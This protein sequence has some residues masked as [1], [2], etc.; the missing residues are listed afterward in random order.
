MPPGY[1]ASMTLSSSTGQKA[2]GS[3]PVPDVHLERESRLA[4]V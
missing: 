1:D 2:G 4:F 3:L